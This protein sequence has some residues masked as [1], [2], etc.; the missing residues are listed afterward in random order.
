MISPGA[1]TITR[2]EFYEFDLYGF[3]SNYTLIGIVKSRSSDTDLYVIDN[4]EING[5]QNDDV[6][7]INQSI[8]DVCSKWDDYLRTFRLRT[9]Y[10][11]KVLSVLLENQCS[12]FKSRTTL[13]SSATNISALIEAINNTNI[14]DLVSVQPMLQPA[15]LFVFGDKVHKTESIA[16]NSKVTYYNQDQSAGPQAICPMDDC[17]AYNKLFE[18]YENETIR[19]ICSY[20]L[21]HKVKVN[22]YS[23]DHAKER[24]RAFIDALVSSPTMKFGKKDNNWALCSQE[25]LHKLGVFGT[26]Y[27]DDRK[28]IQPTAVIY[29]NNKPITVYVNESVPYLTMI[30]GCKGD[31]Y[32]SGYV[33]APYL[34]INDKSNALLNRYGRSLID[35]SY[36]CVLEIIKDTGL[37]SVDD[38]D[39]ITTTTTPTTGCPCTTTTATTPRPTITTIPTNTS[40]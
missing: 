24:I 33:L 26:L 2:R 18:E 22:A 15:S 19:N 3:T 38:D 13:R 8:S 12:Y 29:H 1:R 4:S 35:P 32:D 28:R 27:V 6:A 31:E 17:T 23:A 40:I 39:P 7:A 21:V 5:R 34:M 37:P 25:T 30:F 16:A 14:F 10:R 36:Y 11:L 9:E 20:S